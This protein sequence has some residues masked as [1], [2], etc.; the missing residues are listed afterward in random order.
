MAWGPLQEIEGGHLRCAQVALNQTI[1]LFGLFLANGAA[2]VS[3]AAGHN[4]SL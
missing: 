1:L 4:L 2:L 3:Q